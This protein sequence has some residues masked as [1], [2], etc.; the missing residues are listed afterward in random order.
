MYTKKALGLFFAL[1]LL[2]PLTADARHNLRGANGRFISANGKSKRVRHD[3][4]AAKAARA[5]YRAHK[6]D[7]SITKMTVGGVKV[8]LYNLTHAGM[9]FGPP[10]TPRQ[11]DK[12]SISIYTESANGVNRA[13]DVQGVRLKDKPKG[14]H[15][16]KLVGGRVT[17]GGS[18]RQHA[19]ASHTSAGRSGI[20]RST[21]DMN[22]ANWKNNGRSLEV[23]LK[24]SA[25][26]RDPKTGQ[27]GSPTKINGTQWDNMG[28][29][30]GL[31]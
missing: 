20:R 2:I 26:P 13:F 10:H 14:G 28:G 4:Q 31:E 15:P 30:L 12:P 18:W 11:T 5:L 25:Q 6:K 19:N 29:G 22:K 21:P 7:N 23:P 16:F 27:L 3:R 17:A 8:R 24:L 1:S 9:I